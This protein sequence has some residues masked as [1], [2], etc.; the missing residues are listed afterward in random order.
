MGD[1][2]GDLY[3]MEDLVDIDNDPARWDYG[4]PG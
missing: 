1:L 3:G 4:E 2:P